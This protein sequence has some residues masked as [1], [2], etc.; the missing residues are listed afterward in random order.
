M[1]SL[2][3]ADAVFPPAV[4]PGEPYLLIGDSRPAIDLPLIIQENVAVTLTCVA[5]RSLPPAELTWLL[6]RAERN[7]TSQSRR[8][9]TPLSAAAGTQLFTTRS[10]VTLNITRDLAGQQVTCVTSHRHWRVRQRASVQL[11]IQCEYL[12]SS[13]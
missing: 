4:P 3:I 8:T 9:V 1:A 13:Y 6:G 10:H 12:V 11:D 5:E 2:V 7:V